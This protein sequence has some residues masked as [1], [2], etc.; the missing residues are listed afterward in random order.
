M[1]EHLQ[2]ILL[3]R[4]YWQQQ[5]EEEDES[6]GEGYLSDAEDVDTSTHYTSCPSPDGPIWTVEDGTVNGVHI[7]VHVNHISSK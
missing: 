3:V 5:L 4:D 6:S 2:S 1:S 7:D